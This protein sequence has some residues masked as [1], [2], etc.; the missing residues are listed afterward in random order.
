MMNANR[1]FGIFLLFLLLFS[2]KTLKTEATLQKH[3]QK[4][5]LKKKKEKKVDNYCL[6]KKRVMFPLMNY[7]N[8]FRI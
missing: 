4:I 5:V 2:L 8:T 3:K 1:N 7:L 6:K